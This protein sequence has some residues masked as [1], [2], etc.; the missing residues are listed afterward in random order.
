MTRQ[1]VLFAG[2]EV[3]PLDVAGPAAV[4]AQAGECLGDDRFYE[5]KLVSPEGG[6]IRTFSGIEYLTTKAAH[7]DAGTI[8]TF[9]MMGHKPRGT[10][11]IIAH[12]PS[13]DWFKKARLS[14]R[15]WG[16]VC[17]GAYILASWGL[18]D[19][20]RIA[21]HWRSARRLQEDFP[22]TR[23]DRDALYVCDG[24]LW[25]SA[26]VTA[27]IDMALSMV[28]ADCGVDIAAAVARHLVVYI[29]RP[30]NQ[31]QFSAPLKT[32]TRADAPYHELINW[33]KSNLD[34]DLSVEALAAHA[35]QSLR[36]F[37]RRFAECAGRSPA[38][39]VEDLRLERAR[40]L[41]SGDVP[42]KTVA[43]ETGFTSAAQ[44]STVFRRRLG[45]SPSVWKS[46]HGGTG[47]E[48]TEYVF[49]E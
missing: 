46:M 26:G 17:G 11:D 28:E 21:T 14:A 38:A 18:V 9:L 2:H 15:R 49:P 13:R 20:K 34:W 44:M 7:Y 43:R 41:L 4:F 25:T 22:R 3:Q 19:E 5:V 30:G 12:E 39:F 35:G 27:G 48:A 37:Q 45:L 29:R 24:N 40:A 23:V 8:D 6:P 33:A 31:S 42:V 16:S 36:T 47:E 32:Q 10:I 1:I